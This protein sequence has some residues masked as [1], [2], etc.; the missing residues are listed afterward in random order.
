[1][2]ILLGVYTLRGVDFQGLHED[3]K[4][5]QVCRGFLNELVQIEEKKFPALLAYNPFG[6]HTGLYIGSIYTCMDTHTGYEGLRG[7]NIE[8]GLGSL[9]RGSTKSIFSIQR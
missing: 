7:V 1:M 2:Q 6:A 9:C 4:H 8:M 3:Y 5:L